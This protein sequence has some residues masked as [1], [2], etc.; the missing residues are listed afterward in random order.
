MKKKMK[1]LCMTLSAAAVLTSCL[2]EEH[3]FGKPSVKEEGKGTIV[4]NLN[5]DAEF[6]TETRA[7]TEGNYR[8]TNN[9]DV[10]IY[11]TKNDNLVLECKGS[12][13][14]DN[15]PKTLDIASYRIEAT[16]GTESAASRND[17]KMF[18][19]STFTIKA[20]DQK[21]VT[22]NCAPTCGK[23]LVAFDGQ[24]SV[25]YDDYNVSF[26]G[27][28]ALGSNT[29]SWAK[30]D[31]DPY[32][33]ALTEDGENVKYT[34]SLTA[35]DEYLHQNGNNTGKT[36]TAEGTFKLERNKAHK[37]TIKPNYIPTTSGGM[38]LSI[39]IDESTNDENITYEIPVTW[40]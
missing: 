4:L 13:L 2:S 3:E 29:I 15:L 36:G 18:G 17:F 6:S 38:Q 22:V 35:K 11:N 20:N 16:Y 26:G 33:V 9:Y 7:L 27:T 1:L 28:K 32:Y 31:S 40:L 34:I 10:R 8:N 12:E 14:N 39:T 24:M 19:Q 23:I 25:Y 30:T 21:T 37:L 5:A